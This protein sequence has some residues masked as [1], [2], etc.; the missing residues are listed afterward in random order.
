MAAPAANQVEDGRETQRTARET[1][2]KLVNNSDW[3]LLRSGA[4]SVASG[5]KFKSGPESGVTRADSRA[6]GLSG[7]RLRT[8][9][10]E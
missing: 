1:L 4:G 6:A 9:S 2:L 3:E 7:H 10:S 8:G 5:G